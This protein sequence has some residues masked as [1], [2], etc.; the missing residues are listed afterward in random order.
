[1][2]IIEALEFML[3]LKEKRDSDKNIK[4]EDQLIAFKSMQLS[5]QSVMGGS[6][7]LSAKIEEHTESLSQLAGEQGA[8]QQQKLK[9]KLQ[10]DY[11]KIDQFT[12]SQQEGR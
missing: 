9:D 3:L 4:R 11:T 8:I 12:Q 2:S 7:E 5:A 10:W 6:K 1:M